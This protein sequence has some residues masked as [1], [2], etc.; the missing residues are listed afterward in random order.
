MNN[1][2][3]HT[4]EGVRDIYNG[5]FQRKQ[6]LNRNL[7]SHLQRYGY[8][9]IQTPTF[10]FFDIFS[11]DVG[12]TPS[13][14]L[15]KFFDRDGNT[16]VLRPDFTPS[17]A[18]A[19]SKYFDVENDTVRLCYTGNVFR[20]NLSLQGRLKEC[21][22]LGAELFGDSSPDSDA[23]VIAMVVEALKLAGLKEF[24]ISLG[25]AEIFRSLL[26]AA[27][28]DEDEEEKIR[29]LIFNHNSFGVEEF[30]TRNGVDGD[31]RKLFSLILKMYTSPE[32]FLFAVQLAEGFPKI[33]RRGAVYLLRTGAHQRIQL[34]HRHHFFC[35]HLRQRR[36]CGEGRPVRQAHG[37]L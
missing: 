37:L 13:A 31:L 6:E 18:R 15:Y 2:L 10:E 4:P 14:E 27:D 7:F 3:L 19:A 30:L 32:D 21:T 11:R 24:Q 12:T 1:R 9:P 8:A 33:K 35:L 34:L 5:E 16:L 22:Q 29:S 26:L 25:H 20:N 23:E 17:I 36:A 28:F